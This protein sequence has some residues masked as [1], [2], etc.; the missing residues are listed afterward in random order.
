MSAWSKSFSEKDS[1]EKVLDL[2]NYLYKDI[3][4]NKYGESIY[5][6]NNNLIGYKIDMGINHHNQNKYI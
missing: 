4:M 6:K 2:K 5:D 3:I 1:S